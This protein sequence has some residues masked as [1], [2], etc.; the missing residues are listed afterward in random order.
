[1]ADA[2]QTCIIVLV[3]VIVLWL[4][5][6][7]QSLDPSDYGLEYD[8]WSS[9]VT[10]NNGMAFTAGRYWV[11]LT[12]RFIIFPAMVET[13]E[14]SNEYSNDD[15]LTMPAIWSRTSDGLA[16]ELE[17]SMQYQ[18][19]PTNI[20]KLYRQLGTFEAA[21]SYFAQLAK[22]LIMTEATHYSAHQFFAN[23]TTIQPLI[24]EELRQVFK[25]RLFASLQF[26]QLQ[27]I[28]LPHEFEDAIRNTTLTLQEITISQAL[29]DKKAV[30][31][32]TELLKM[33]QHVSVRLNEAKAQAIE[34][35]LDGQ[36][37][38]QRLLLQAQAD[39]SAI[40]VKARATANATMIQR[41][42]DAASVLA[43]RRAE[44]A[45]VRLKSQ[46]YFNATNVSYHSQ[47]VSYQGMLK[48]VGSE[49][50]FLELMKVQALQNVSWKGMTVSVSK[51]SDPLS[52]MGLASS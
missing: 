3:A 31:W 43:A 34:V 26:F 12:K 18:L 51:G 24:E 30:E 49:D 41:E 38:G 10:D 13:I 39:A 16:V 52:F 19:M 28:I 42:A 21:Q 46:T 1:M 35:E 17:C 14:F 20:T 25:D 27:K 2:L 36:A 6:S 29:R 45:T 4:F 47:A 15:G 44:A 23:R 5:F 22:S 40:L 9:T 48:A 8:W 11:G 7:F 50:R 32:E 33:E 37:K